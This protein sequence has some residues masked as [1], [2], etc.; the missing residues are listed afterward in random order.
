MDNIEELLQKIRDKYDKDGEDPA[1]YLE[2]LYHQKYITY[3]EYIQTGVLLN[4][5]NPVTN[6]PDEMVFITY[7]QITEL[8]FKLAL[9]ECKQIREASEC[10]AEFLANRLARIRNY[11]QHLSHSFSIMREGMEPEQFLQFR[12]ALTPAS[13]FQSVQFRYIELA[14]TPL[15]NLVEHGKRKDLQDHSPEE[16]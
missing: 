5:Q 16:Q 15:I 7:H 4:L 8:Y 2:G 12:M 11:F 3:W 14:M 1:I 10:S 13:G 9:W 6:L